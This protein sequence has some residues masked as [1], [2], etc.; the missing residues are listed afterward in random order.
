MEI[1]S[2][3]QKVAKVRAVKKKKKS[4]GFSTYCQ[5][6]ITFA[7]SLDCVCL[8]VFPKTFEGDI[9]HEASS[10]ISQYVFPTLDRDIF[11]L[12]SQYKY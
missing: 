4:T 12:K 6:F 7:L 5:Q 2:N 1:I 10:L 11:L 8:C 9:L 3:L